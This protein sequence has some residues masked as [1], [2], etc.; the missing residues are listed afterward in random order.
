MATAKKDYAAIAAAAIYQPQDADAPTKSRKKKI[1]VYG[2]Q[3][4]GKTTFAMSAPN[5]LMIDPEFGSDD[6]VE[7]NPHIWPVRSWAEM[8][9]VYYFLRSNPDCPKHKGKEAH[10]FEWVGVDGMTKLANYALRHVMKVEEERSL[11][12]IPGL[13]QQ[14][15]YGKAGELMKDMMSQFHNLDLGVI[16]TA[17]ERQ[18]APW[19]G[20]EDEDVEEAS[21][22]YVPDLPK[23]VRGALLSLVDVIGRLYIVPIEKDGKRLPQRRLW[24]GPSLQYDTGFRSD[25]VLPDMLK[26]PTVPRLNRLLTTGS[27][28]LPKK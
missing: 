6:K 12:R 23:G 3:K 28:N 26:V 7:K 24:I 17:Q 9:D 18:D 8:N 22:S 2:R 5:I 11:E 14:R 4:K 21:V 16:Y 20:D 25:Y 27:A 1:L 13:V 15:D 19:A 10:K